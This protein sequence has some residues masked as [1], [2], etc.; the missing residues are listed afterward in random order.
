M[1][2]FAAV[3]LA[4]A[5]VVQAAAPP[6]IDVGAFLS[7]VSIASVD[8]ADDDSI[9]A[10]RFIVEFEDPQGLRKR[11]PQGDH[12]REFYD[13]LKKKGIVVKPRFNYTSDILEGTSLKLGKHFSRKHLE[14]LPDVKRVWPVRKVRAPKFEVKSEGEAAAADSKRWTNHAHTGVLDLHK[15]GI[16]GK[17]IVVGV[18]D[19]G[20]DYTNPAFGGKMGPE[21]TVI[22]GKDLVGND[23]MHDGFVPDDDPIDCFG[24]GTHVSGI[25]AGVT[26]KYIGVAPEAKIR[27]YKVFGCGDGTSNEALVNAFL[28]AYEDGVDIITASIGGPGGWSNDLW[29]ET[30]NR[31]AKKGVFVSIAS[32]N[33]GSTGPFYAS[34]GN[35]GDE[36]VSVNSIDNE[37]YLA[38]MADVTIGNETFAVPYL[39]PTGKGF[40]LNGSI[41]ITPVSRDINDPADGCGPIS[42]N[43]TGQIA[44]LRRGGCVFAEKFG[45]ATKAGAEYVWVYNDD[46][47]LVYLFAGDYPT[48]KGYAM[49]E[50]A[51]GERIVQ[52]SG[53]AYVKFRTDSPEGKPN[54]LTG[55]TISTYTSWGPTWEGQ[56]KGQVAAPGGNILS[57]WPMAKGGI[58]LVSGTSMACPYVAGIAALYMSKYGGRA[59]LGPEGVRELRERITSSGSPL[60]WNDGSGTD[61]SI[62]A[63]V[64]Q[65]GTG[66][67]NAV[68]VLEYKTRISPAVLELNDTANFKGEHTVTI[69]NKGKKPVTLNIE[70]NPAQTFESFYLSGS[71]ETVIANFPPPFIA[72]SATVDFGAASVAV[73][74]GGSKAITVKFTAPALSDTY[75]PVYSGFLRLSASTGEAH[76]VAYQ[77]ISG[78]LRDRDIWQPSRGNPTIFKRSYQGTPYKLVGAP[79]LAVNETALDISKGEDI[80]VQYFNLWGTAE[81]RWDVYKASWTPSDFVYPPE[82]S[83]AWVGSVQTVDD[84]TFPAY[85]M[86]RKDQLAGRVDGVVW[87]GRL[88]DNTTIASGDYILDFRALRVSGDPKKKED[89]MSVQTPELQVIGKD[90]GSPSRRLKRSY[91]PKPVKFEEVETVKRWW[92]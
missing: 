21:Y 31:L 14:K 6:S 43:L 70:H 55:G 92:Q 51:D 86:P 85:Y 58:S 10:G 65:Q 75:L 36:V 24:H 48:P 15:K 69:F 16:K 62:L 54:T 66:Y 77:G 76:T 39:D 56:I 1:R 41:P 87:M 80:R 60:N 4:V 25:V 59:K 61:A 52:S 22:G 40:P 11:S 29:A 34:N 38:W 57:A 9:I 63:P 12:F 91:P 72:G 28:L 81:L 20:T 64:A 13:R 73:P 79:P 74:A 30:A 37:D 45:N 53:Q 46:R 88:T 90:G 27:S 42:A 67:V 49:I 50:K 32:G 2:S 71:G 83:D 35:V 33:A 78:N 44:L 26:D 19:S 8:D 7:D 89:W 47:P 5:A 68:E 18:V 3:V 17:G 23:Y 82:N 84:K